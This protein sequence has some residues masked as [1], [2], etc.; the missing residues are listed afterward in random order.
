MSKL[1]LVI[2]IFIWL[3]PLCGKAATD[4]QF[5]EAEIAFSLPDTWDGKG[6][7]PNRVPPK[8]DST[9]PLFMYWK[10]APLTGK[11]GNTISAGL[12]V[13]VFNVQPDANVV[14]ASSSLMRHR[15]WPFKQL[16]TSEKDG[17]T[18]PNSLGY[19]TEFSPRDGLLMKIFVVHA[20]NNGKFV[21]VNLSVSDDIFA[22]IEPECR[23]VLKSLRL[24][25]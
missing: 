21:E 15:G 1:K 24:A 6:I 11:N 19:L 18:L 20:I 7:S 23:S 4:I 14:L 12:N 5:Q 13:T 16:L 10:R 8:M 25:K 22:Q 17:L 9:D 2:G 3:I